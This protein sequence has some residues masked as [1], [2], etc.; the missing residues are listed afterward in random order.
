MPGTPRPEKTIRSPGSSVRT[1][2]ADSLSNPTLFLCVLVA[3]VGQ[4]FRYL[5]AGNKLMNYGSHFSSLPA[6]ARGLCVPIGKGFSNVSSDAE[7]KCQELC[8]GL[9]VL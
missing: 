8:M 2:S 9:A 4:L 3:S 1:V 6:G 7:H 5:P